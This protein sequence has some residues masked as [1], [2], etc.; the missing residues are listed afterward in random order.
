MYLLLD[1]AFAWA[2]RSLKAISVP[3]VAAVG[4]NHPDPAA[5]AASA[6][7][8][9]LK[10]DLGKAAAGATGVPPKA[11]DGGTNGAD[12]GTTTASASAAPTFQIELDGDTQLRSRPI[13]D[14]VDATEQLIHGWSACFVGAPVNGCAPPNAPSATTSRSRARALP[15][16]LTFTEL[17]KLL[18]QIREALADI[19][20]SSKGSSSSVSISGNLSSLSET[21]EQQL[22]DAVW[23][24][25]L[26]QYM[27]GGILSVSNAISSQFASAVLMAAPLAATPVTLTLTTRSSD[28]KGGTPREI[29]R[30]EDVVSL[31]Y[32]RMTQ[33][34]MQQWGL[35][36]MYTSPPAFRVSPVW[37]AKSQK[38]R[39][40][41]AGKRIEEGEEIQR[42]TVEGDASTA[43]YFFGF[44]AVTGGKVTVNISRYLKNN[45]SFL[46]TSL[47]LLL[48][49]LSL[50]LLLRLHV[51]L[52]N[53]VFR[54]LNGP[55]YASTRH[56][57][58]HR[59]GVTERQSKL[60]V[61][62]LMYFPF[63]NSSLQ[64]DSDF[65]LLLAALGFGKIL[66]QEL[67][68][69]PSSISSCSAGCV[70]FCGVSSGQISLKHNALVN[71]Q[72]MSDCLPT[73]TA[74]AAAACTSPWCCSRDAAAGGSSTLACSEGEALRLKAA[75]LRDL[76]ALTQQQQSQQQHQPGSGSSKKAGQAFTCSWTAAKETEW[77]YLCIFGVGCVRYKESDR[78]EA[79]VSQLQEAGITAW[80]GADYVALAV[81]PPASQAEPQKR[82]K[83][84][85][86]Q[87]LQKP[88]RSSKNIL[89]LKA[90]GDHRLAMSWAV[91][92]IRRPD[93]YVEEVRP[94]C[95]RCC[96]GSHSCCRNC[97]SA[98]VWVL[99]PYSCDSVLCV[100]GL[101]GLPAD[102]SAFF[103]C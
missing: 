95:C 62:L 81:P 94:C 17:L 53:P 13:G 42:F 15:V 36:C 74:I 91:L 7:S 66:A 28:S 49:R 86:Q 10:G 77:R 75:L 26:Q 92:G 59:Q 33:R 18:Q 82:A 44:A 22:K 11:W 61:F 54:F 73:L 3:A 98:V 56:K 80:C 71:L 102:T 84:H 23:Q 30:E 76:E 4:G 16:L 19:T 57:R 25:V 46:V 21:E 48:L 85:H 29:E 99:L 88:C 12:E 52:P 60:C 78:L 8:H 40:T 47:L 93:V 43:S 5:I 79:V 72:G 89:S 100:E 34:L 65:P 35:E 103:C 45:T 38:E 51:Y 41:D 39:D 9:G 37:P 87:Q 63:R 24:R 83:N 50:L 97:F 69:E 90:F 14:L 64:G 101:A 27:P 6:A 70:T 68:H 1:S 31:P 67:P 32:L 2:W 55:P 58:N 96:V 20:T